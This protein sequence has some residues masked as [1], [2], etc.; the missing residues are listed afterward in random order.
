[1]LYGAPLSKEKRMTKRVV[2]K[3]DGRYLIYYE[4]AAERRVAVPA[5]AA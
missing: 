3:D 5:P 4:K 1:M 2:R